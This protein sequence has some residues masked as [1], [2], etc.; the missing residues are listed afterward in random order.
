M[1]TQNLIR[2]FRIIGLAEGISYLVLLG[3]S[4]PLKYLA[5]IPEAVKVNGWIHGLLFVLFVAGAI[6]VKFATRRSWLWLA[7]AFV[8]SLVPFGTFV[9]DRQLR[10]RA[11]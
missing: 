2:N 11:V 9:L 5:H 1:N 10:E 3:I 6:W 7:G 8:A 4:M